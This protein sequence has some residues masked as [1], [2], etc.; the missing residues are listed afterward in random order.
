[1]EEQVLAVGDAVRVALSFAQAE[2]SGLDPKEAARIR[3]EHDALQSAWQKL[4]DMRVEAEQTA[5]SSA[6]KAL[7]GSKQ[8]SS[9]KPTFT[10]SSFADQVAA[11]RALA[12]RDGVLEPDISERF[13]GGYIVIPFAGAKAATEIQTIVDQLKGIDPTVDARTRG[14]DL[15]V[16]SD[17]RSPS[18]SI[19]RAV[20]DANKDALQLIEALSSEVTAGRKTVAE[21][22]QI[23]S[24]PLS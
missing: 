19:V 5:L 6:R 10:V 8:G 14:K 3:D 13:F 24:S 15:S 23:L 18:A 16:T 4:V 12:E 1:M 11:A 2:A 21:V 20:L 7:T 22:K 17:P 9:W